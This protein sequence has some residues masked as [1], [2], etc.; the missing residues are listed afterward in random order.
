MNAVHIVRKHAYEEQTLRLAELA[1]EMETYIIPDAAP[2]GRV[3]IIVEGVLFAQ[4]L[5]VFIAPQD[6][7][8]LPGA[9]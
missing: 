8:A 1:P 7:H 2:A 5:S 9:G 3:E 6:R 4:K